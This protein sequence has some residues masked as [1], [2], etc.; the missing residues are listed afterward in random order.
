MSVLVM[1][2]SGREMDEETQDHV[3]G[4]EFTI[5]IPHIRTYARLENDQWITSPRYDIAAFGEWEHEIFICMHNFNEDAVRVALDRVAEA[6][7]VPANS[8]EYELDEAFNVESDRR[9]EYVQYA[10]IL[11]S[12]SLDNERSDDVWRFLTEHGMKFVMTDDAKKLMTH[13]CVVLLQPGENV[14]VAF[15]SMDT[16]RIMHTRLAPEYHVAME[17]SFQCNPYD[18]KAVREFTRRKFRRVLL[19]CPHAD[20]RSIEDS[21]PFRVDAVFSAC[22]IAHSKNK[23]GEL[24]KRHERGMRKRLRE[25][26]HRL[27]LRASQRENVH[28]SRPAQ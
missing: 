7:K 26:D 14:S 10:R 19:I 15:R 24:M 18:F 5:R 9:V 23:L 3:A 21:V 25:F 22:E 12:K 2:S 6:C 16:K 17:F 13:A 1:L 4:V 27:A 8:L 20:H 28:D 11:R